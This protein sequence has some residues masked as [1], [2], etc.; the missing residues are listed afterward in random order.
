[1]P[2]PPLTS[3][4]PRLSLTTRLVLLARRLLA[5]TYD[6]VVL[7]GLAFTAA[8]PVVWLA[9]GP[10][11]GMGLL[12]LQAWL[13]LVCGAYVSLAWRRSGMTLGM[14][15]WDIEVTDAS[16]NRPDLWR[17]VLRFLLALAAV[18][19]VGVGLWWS[20]V[21]REGRGLHDRLSGT[22]VRRR[23]SGHAAGLTR[24]A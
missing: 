11:Q 14:Q 2:P 12:G 7:S 10:P 18:G 8:L 4:F 1:M 3:V 15:A 13:L 5:L 23:G 19:I 17:A 22:G 20:L 6:L 24:G 9:G 16:G 21:D